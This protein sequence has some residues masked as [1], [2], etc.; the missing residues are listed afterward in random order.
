MPPAM[1]RNAMVALLATLA[2]RCKTAGAD[3]DATSSFGEFGPLVM[4]TTNVAV[5]NAT[6]VPNVTRGHRNT[7]VHVTTAPGSVAA[8]P[9]SSGQAAVQAATTSGAPAPAPASTGTTPS[10]TPPGAVTTTAAGAVTTAA[11]GAGTTTATATAAGA[12]TTTAAGAGGSTQI[13]WTFD[14]ASIAVIVCL[15]LLLLGL[16]VFFKHRSA[17]PRRDPNYNLANVEVVPRRGQPQAEMQEHRAVLQGTSDGRRPHGRV[18]NSGSLPKYAQIPASLP[19]YQ[20]IKPGD[21]NTLETANMYGM[22]SGHA[23]RAGGSVYDNRPRGHSIVR[24]RDGRVTLVLANKGGDAEATAL[25]EEH[26]YGLA[27]A[28]RPQVDPDGVYANRM[29]PRLQE[30]G[31]GHGETACDHDRDLDTCG[32]GGGGGRAAAAGEHVY[33]IHHHSAEDQAAHAVEDEV[34]DNRAGPTRAGPVH[35]DLYGPA[36]AGPTP[37]VTEGVGDGEADGENIYGRR[38]PSPTGL[39][40]GGGSGYE[41]GIHGS[42]QAPANGGVPSSGVRLPAV[43]GAEARQFDECVYGPGSPGSPS[44][45]TQ[46]KMSYMYAVP[47]PL[48]ERR[49][50][51]AIEIDSPARAP[52]T[53]WVHT[54]PSPGVSAGMGARPSQ[55]ATGS[56][57]T[58]TAATLASLPHASDDVPP[59]LPTRLSNPAAVEVGAAN[60]KSR[61]GSITSVRSAMSEANFVLAHGNDIGYD[62]GYVECGTG[63]R[64]SSMSTTE[65]APAPKRRSRHSVS[66]LV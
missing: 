20:A 34:Y 26:T 40:G 61:L 64:P 35:D 3:L 63:S 54:S 55:R 57:K 7:T 18:G 29:L 47:T 21:A 59:A 5:T 46:R 17:K 56:T 44:F 10:N 49:S 16:V 8:S 51:T 30:D 1:F 39:A 58:L 52:Y 9:T 60:P 50:E 41:A 11:A 33:G 12:G 6:V 24:G 36:A 28:R 45:S 15:A 23:E 27:P 37:R 19:E 22:G 38:S 25:A 53:S 62:I 42:E 14:G 2:S 13:V 66:S 65:L 31:A 4:N 43:D 48:Q 32:G